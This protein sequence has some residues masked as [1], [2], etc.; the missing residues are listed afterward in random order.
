MGHIKSWLQ[1]QQTFMKIN[2]IGL[3]K[4][5]LKAYFIVFLFSSIL[6]LVLFYG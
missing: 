1:E 4:I 6:I 3:L 2:M 5:L